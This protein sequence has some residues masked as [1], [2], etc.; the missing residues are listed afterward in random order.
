VNEGCA[1]VRTT[2]EFFLTPLMPSHFFSARSHALIKLSRVADVDEA[3]RD[4]SQSAGKNP[5]SRGN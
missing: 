4:V 5:E 1:N 2:E 3:C